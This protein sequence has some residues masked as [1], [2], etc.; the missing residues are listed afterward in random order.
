MTAAVKKTCGTVTATQKT[1]ARVFIYLI[2]AAV[3]ITM[4]Y[5]F[6][7]MFFTS[8]KTGNEV[9]NNFTVYLWPKEFTTDNYIDIFRVVPFANGFLNT[10]IIEVSVITVGT[11][12]TILGTF[13]FAK[14]R[15]PGKNAIFLMLLG[16]MM[17]PFI[18]VLS[19]QYSAFTALNLTDSLWPLILPGLFGNL[20]MM[21]FLRQYMSAI[22]DQLFEAAKIDG[23]GYFGMCMRIMLPLAVPA[24]GT[25]V[26]FWFL[27][28][29]N[30]VLGPDI[31]LTTLENKTLQVMLRYLNV[32]SGGGTLLNQPLMMAGATLSSLPILA[33]YIGFQKYFVNAMML[34]GIKG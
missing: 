30:D 22:P 14:M 7:W 8:F 1:A 4:L 11:F 23:A 16:G 21:F 13:A 19:P 12:V 9:V 15:F 10:M 17:I 3:S 33:L 26:I 18:V 28:I 32:Q 6:L 5:P 27:G 31:Y 25:H 20:G 24:I 29:W 34:S 2:L